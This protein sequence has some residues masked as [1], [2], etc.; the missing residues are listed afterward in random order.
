MLLPPRDR[1]EDGWKS[2]LPWVK[3]MGDYWMPKQSGQIRAQTLRD[4]SLGH[5]TARQEE[6]GLYDARG[7][8]HN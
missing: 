5:L 7:K 3:L 8:P 6:L 2:G 4:Y 1:A